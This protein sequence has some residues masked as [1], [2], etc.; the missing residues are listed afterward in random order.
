[1]CALN[2][3]KH[4]NNHFQTIIFLRWRTRTRN[5]VTILSSR[6]ISLNFSLH[7]LRKLRADRKASARYNLNITSARPLCASGRFR[8]RALAARGCPYSAC[9]CEC[10]PWK[11]F[12]IFLTLAAANVFLGNPLI[13][14]T[15]F[16]FVYPFYVYFKQLYLILHCFCTITYLS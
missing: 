6:N 14:I 15:K 11:P 12:L 13:F 7:R 8:R 5:A 1:M 3:L 10:L 2:I 4:H 16:Y 9:D